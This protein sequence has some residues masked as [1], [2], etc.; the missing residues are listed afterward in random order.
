[1]LFDLSVCFACACGHI[2]QYGVGMQHSF[3][4]R[5]VIDNDIFVKVSSVL[6]GVFLT[7]VPRQCHNQQKLAMYHVIGLLDTLCIALEFRWIFTCKI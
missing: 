1:M 4:F 2:S 7:C 6:R 3:V 5:T